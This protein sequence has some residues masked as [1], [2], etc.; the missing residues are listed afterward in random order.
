MAKKVLLLIQQFPH[1]VYPAK[2]LV[3]FLFTGSEHGTAGRLP[4]RVK[5]WGATVCPGQEPMNG[6]S[7]L[8][9]MAPGYLIHQL[10]KVGESMHQ[11]AV[12]RRFPS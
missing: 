8:G 6:G 9:V 2:A 7:R 5:D 4:V 12:N 1:Y 10:R 3:H 11:T